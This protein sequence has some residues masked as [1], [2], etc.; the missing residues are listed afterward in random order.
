MVL[1]DCAGKTFFGL[2]D[3]TRGSATML[4]L[5]VR[6]TPPHAVVSRQQSTNSMPQ[7]HRQLLSCTPQPCVRA[8]DLSLNPEQDCARPTHLC[9]VGS[10]LATRVT[11]VSG[12][13]ILWPSSSTAYPH[14]TSS[15]C[16][17]PARSPSYVVSTTP[18]SLR[19]ASR[20]SSLQEQSR[21][22]TQASE[23]CH[24]SEV[25]VSTTLACHLHHRVLLKPAAMFLGTDSQE[26]AALVIRLVTDMRHSSCTQQAVGKT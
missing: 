25:G 4:M 5:F 8:P 24:P 7:A 11:S 15:R 14:R 22:W 20:T 9:R 13:R 6:M 18:A 26:M 16:S 2:A 19:A 21:C 10:C 1:A 17:R 3:N 12:F 23:T